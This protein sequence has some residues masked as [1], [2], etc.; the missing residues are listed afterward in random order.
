LI[1]KNNQH[2]NHSERRRILKDIKQKAHIKNPKVLIGLQKISIERNYDVGIFCLSE[3][4]DN[5]LMWSHYSNCHKGICYIF[6]SDRNLPFFASALPITYSEN[7]PKLNFLT[8]SKDSLIID[9]MFLT[10]STDW[11][12]E[13][14][15][16]IFDIEN[17]PGLRE[18]PG[19]LLK[20]VIFG[21]RISKADLQT[22]AE[23][24]IKRNNSIELYRTE[25]MLDKYGLTL[26]N[27]EI[28]K[29]LI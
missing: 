7:Y 2:G 1:K 27:D 6:K 16:R 20:G 12:Y 5:K 15:R 13:K 25:E 26:R 17:G 21:C 10:K 4:W 9:K 3:V 8:A 18:F 14:E 28:S 11:S 19:C 23:I 29:T 24:L 22:A